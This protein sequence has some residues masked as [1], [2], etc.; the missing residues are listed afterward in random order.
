MAKFEAT[1]RTVIRDEVW[2]RGG[3]PERV[4]GGRGSEGWVMVSQQSLVIWLLQRDIIGFWLFPRSRSPSVNFLFHQKFHQ[5]LCIL[6]IVISLTHHPACVE[7]VYKGTAPSPP[8]SLHTPPPPCTILLHYELVDTDFPFLPATRSI[9][10]YIHK[11]GCGFLA[12]MSVGSKTARI[13]PTSKRIDNA[14]LFWDIPP[15]KICA[16][17]ND[18]SACFCIQK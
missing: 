11:R 9:L 3:A 10:L 13:S 4:G 14:V 8:I 17:Y 12:T 5:G 1:N 2:E 16:I 18:F 6:H 7:A 15:S